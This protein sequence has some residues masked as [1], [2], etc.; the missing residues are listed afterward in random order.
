MDHSDIAALSITPWPF[1]A[2]TYADSTMPTEMRYS[3]R[4]MPPDPKLSRPK[5]TRIVARRHH[6]AS[7]SA[8]CVAL[9]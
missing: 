2:Q 3:L 4:F 5:S 1:M 7:A 8:M 9:T 6:L